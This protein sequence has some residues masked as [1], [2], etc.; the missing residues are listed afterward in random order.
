M[1]SKKRNLFGAGSWPADDDTQRAFWRLADRYFYTQ[2]PKSSKLNETA[3]A[4]DLPKLAAFIGICPESCL[5]AFDWEP[6]AEA[7]FNWIVSSPGSDAEHHASV[8]RY[9][10]K[11]YIRYCSTRGLCQFQP[12]A[13]TVS[14]RADR[15]RNP[16]A[17]KGK[18][19]STPGETVKRRR[20]A[21]NKRRPGAKRS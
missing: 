12:V 21:V 1:V 20:A 16:P 5:S 2:D 6:E 17:L 9:L 10:R 18:A 11:E 19:S 8:R 4:I 14:A 3:R 7:L 15:R 13:N